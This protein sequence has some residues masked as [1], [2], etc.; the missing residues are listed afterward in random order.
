M[1][2]PV[3]ANRMKEVKNMFKPYNFR[4]NYGKIQ[5][6][7]RYRTCSNKTP[8]ISWSVLTDGIYNNTVDNI[9]ECNAFQSA[10]RIVFKSDNVELWDSGW[11]ESCEQSVR[12]AGMPLPIGVRI[13]FSVEIKDK[14]GNVSLPACDYFYMGQ[15]DQW[16]AKWIAASKDEKRRAIY[17]S[18]KFYLEKKPEAAYLLISGLG[19]Q[20][21]TIN[22][23]CVDESLMDPAYSD[24]SRTCYYV[25]MPEL[26][27]TLYEGENEICCAIGDGWRRLDSDFIKMATG[28]RNIP[29]D[30]IPQLSAILYVKCEGKWVRALESDESWSWSHGPL[31]SQNIYDGDIY[32][33]REA[34]SIPEAVIT[35]S[36]PGGKMIVQELEP[37]RKKAIY[38]PISISPIK[39]DAYVIDFGQNM[40]GYVK[41]SLPVGAECGRKIEI[42][43]SELLK[44][45]G[46]LFTEPLREAKCTD[47][48]FT[49][50]N[51]KYGDT[52]EPDFTFHG[53]R[54]AKV[55]GYGDILSSNDIV[56]I[57]FY[58]DIEKENNYFSCGSALV[59][60][61]HENTVMCERSNLHSILSDCPQRN[62]RMAWM[63]D[64][65]VRFEE[66]PYNFDIGRIFPK[67]I[68]DIIDSQKEEDRITCT[69]PYIVG[70]RPADPVCSSFLVAGVSSLYHTGNL[71][72]IDRAYE[73]FKK[74][75]DYLLSRSENYIVDY[76][77]YGDWASPV[78]CCVALEDAKS[79]ITPGILMS[80]GYSFYNCIQL[81]NFASFLGKT[82]DA[83]YYLRVSESIKKAFLD[84][85]FDKNT[86]I[87]ATG[88]QACQVFPLWLGIIPAEYIDKALVVLREDLVKRNYRI[89]TGNLCTRYIFDV[90]TE[91]GYVDD[92]WE[93]IT[94]E[95][96]PSLGY[97]IQN[98]ATTIWERF[99]LKKDPSMNSHNHPMYG[100]V[101]YW[102]YAYICGVKPL[103]PGWKEFSVKPYFPTKL[104]SAKCNVE[105]PMGNIAVRWVKQYGKTELHID[106]PFGCIAHVDFGNEKKRLT[107]GVYHLS[108]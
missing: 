78:D 59:N 74:W 108:C 96:Y 30:G 81:S 93:I 1:N 90:L 62:E 19:Y 76:S 4:L 37:I 92:A 86:G 15:V 22:G 104:L 73:N 42:K 83:E 65:T 33:A 100:A 31:I 17:F 27:D 88:S 77:Y 49:S 107:C 61:I 57:S 43:Y 14:N 26:E 3:F 101:D 45:D 67:V 5:K 16:D 64:A 89:T 47:V 9:E 32:D 21:V 12:Y 56:A 103:S 41:L 55:T 97:M 95:K 8:L 35:L 52:W 44:E 53:F 98:E 99:E 75:E 2:C 80:T 63:N 11:Q 23:K 105:T 68:N 60:K 71:E 106:V 85:W 102:L 79:A 10:Y 40:A 39:H 48:Y 72:I 24:Y 66:T 58:T 28:Y 25:L 54:Y 94:N 29:L 84:K 82:E 70:A 13:D 38:K 87:V 91:N 18:R 69:A 36:S 20:K 51:E 46:D 34:Y 7:A 50:G 6:D